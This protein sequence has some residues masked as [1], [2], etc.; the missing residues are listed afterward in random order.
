MNN[1]PVNQPVD[2]KPMNHIWKG[3]KWN[4][5][6]GRCK[7]LKGKPELYSAPL[8]SS[9]PFATNFGME[10]IGCDAC[11][12][13]SP[14]SFVCSTSSCLFYLQTKL[15]EADTFFC[16]VSAMSQTIGSHQCLVCWHNK[17]RLDNYYWSMLLKLYQGTDME[18]HQAAGKNIINILAGKELTSTS[19]F[20]K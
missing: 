1:F 19:L 13:I 7:S 5:F 20:T 3:M 11:Y 9:S 2:S 14:R 8:D 17:N 15:L 10:G 4:N 6:I 16:S 12:C 18:K